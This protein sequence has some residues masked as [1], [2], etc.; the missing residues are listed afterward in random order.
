MH[1]VSTTGGLMGA[2]DQMEMQGRF[3][4]LVEA[5]TT[6]VAGLGPLLD[7]A[8]QAFGALSTAHTGA[9]GEAVQKFRL[10]RSWSDL[11]ST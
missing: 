6:T 2:L 10:W 5:P 1:F 11:G 4:C 7:T 8:A 3:V 9:T